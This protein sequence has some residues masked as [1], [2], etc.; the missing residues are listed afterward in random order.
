VIGIVGAQHVFVIHR[1]SMT[2]VVYGLL[3]VQVEQ[4][5]IS[6][7][8]GWLTSHA[9]LHLV[10]ISQAQAQSSSELSVSV[11]LLA[12]LQFRSILL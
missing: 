9:E 1:G 4:E 8:Q 10:A 6:S 2:I 7:T 5:V 11:L 12:E 3:I